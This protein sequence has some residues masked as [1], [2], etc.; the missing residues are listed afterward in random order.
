MNKPHKFVSPLKDGQLTQLKDL[1]ENVS[2]RVRMRAHSIILSSKGFGIDD[3]S[4]IYDLYRDSVSS[5]IDAWEKNGIEGLYDLSRCGAPPKLTE[6]ETET[7]K[8][9]IEETPNSPKTVLAKISEKFGKAI[10]MST[11]KN[12][13]RKSNMRW[14]RVRKSVKSKR[15]PKKFEK[16]KKEIE[17]LEAQRRSGDIDLFYFDESGFSI[18]SAVPYAYQPVGETLEIPASADGRLNVAGFLSPDNRFE[19]FC[20]ECSVDSAVV[21]EC[22]NEF[23]KTV[24][25]KTAVIMD[26][27]SF[28]HSDEFEKNRPRW[29]KRGIYIKHLPKYS[30]ELNLIEILWRFIKYRWIPI[31]AYLSYEKLVQTAEYILK[32]IGSEF[33]IDFT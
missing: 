8:K 2:E 33:Q 25:K 29:R 28:H 31:S 11:L 20:F 19:S 1:M 16:A 4:Y 10:C 32:N 12:I 21:V 17:E 30:P 24:V 9:M 7:V 14:K 18:G 26:N 13:I 27:A 5:W 23:S 15:D 3:I 22:F 6:S